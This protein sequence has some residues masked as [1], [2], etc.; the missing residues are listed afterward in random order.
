MATHLVIATQEAILFDPLD[1]GIGS[2]AYNAIRIGKIALERDV[3][4]PNARY[5]WFVRYASD[6]LPLL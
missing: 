3:A 6:L 4:A 5:N 1:R 2:I